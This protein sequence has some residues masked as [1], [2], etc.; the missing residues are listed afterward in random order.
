M[1]YLA[2]ARRIACVLVLLLGAF[3]AE[4]K[5]TEETN[6]AKAGAEYT[7]A[8]VAGLSSVNASEPIAT[9]HLE[10]DP[11]TFGFELIPAASAK[12]FT[13]EEVNTPAAVQSSIAP[14]KPLVVALAE[15]TSSA[16]IREPSAPVVQTPASSQ[17]PTPA[18]FFTINQ[19]L[20]KQKQVTSTTPEMRV[21]AIDPK[22][23]SDASPELTQPTRSDEPFGLFTFRAPDGLLWA[24]WRGVEADIQA[25]APA[26]ARCRAKPTSCTPGAARFVAI[27]NQ[28][29]AHQGRAKLELV[30][31]RVNAAIRYMTDMAQWGVA[32]MWSA[33]LDASGK[34]SFDTGFGDCEDYAIAKFV[35]LREAGV[36]AHDLR[37]LLVHDN[38]VR[39]DHAV[40]AAHQDGH[41]LILDNRWSRLSEDTDVRYFSPLFALDDRGVNLFVAP[42]AARR[43]QDRDTV[44]NGDQSFAAGANDSV[45]ATTPLSSA[46]G[47]GTAPPLL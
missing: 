15:P 13:F 39:L 43:L 2:P 34:G 33:P 40:L 1:K 6:A 19:V 25:E 27:I 36:S 9:A 41:W 16:N 26:L 7:R 32:D 4:R 3:A 31:E 47:N 45:F 44:S 20:A 10:I 12:P 18:R 29:E 35:A 14:T 5:P 38:S 42:Y 24:K 30:N 17:W 11:Q 23:T 46:T 22:I 8:N 28:A 37:L 21:A